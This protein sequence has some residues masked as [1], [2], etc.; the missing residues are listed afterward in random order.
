MSLYLVIVKHVAGRR[1]NLPYSW[2]PLSGDRLVLM[3]DSAD[4]WFDSLRTNPYVIEATLTDLETGE[5]K[6]WG[7]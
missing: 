7:S 1:H 4:H 6:H 3:S 5:K 2:K